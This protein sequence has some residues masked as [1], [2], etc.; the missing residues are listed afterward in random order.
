MVDNKTYRYSSEFG[1]NMFLKKYQILQQQELK[2][3]SK[4]G[5]FTESDPCHIYFILK[6][7][8]ITIDPN[9]FISKESYYELR[10]KIQIKEE[11]V[12][13]IHRFYHPENNKV[14]KIFS[15]YPNNYFTAISETGDI[16]YIK[17]GAFLDT[18]QQEA[19][20]NSPLLDYEVL[21]IGQSYGE[22]GKRT[23]I[24]RLYNHPTLQYIYNE[25]ITKFPDSEIWLM[26]ANFGQK[27]L[28]SVI[29]GVNIY[30]ENE[31]DEFSRFMGFLD[32]DKMKINENQKINFTEA[33]LINLFKPPFN[34]DYKHTFPSMTHV[35]YK[36]CYRLQIN[37]LTINL[38]LSDYNRWLYTDALPR[39]T[40]DEVFKYCHSSNFS[41]IT[42]KDRVKLFHNEYF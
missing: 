38:D 21:Y 4:M 41:F 19:N 18:I 23:A 26:L 13:E 1:I 3:F 36:D 29:G 31:S 12:L 6:R 32:S 40:N 14:V 30:P 28:T 16:A 8:R 35:S 5:V 37:S 11:Y 9:Y 20:Y 22:D 34:K 33:A 24:D 25:A 39:G 27:N 42:D 15:E 10:F 17:V 2:V 7:P